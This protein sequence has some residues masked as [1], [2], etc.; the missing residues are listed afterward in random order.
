[1]GRRNPTPAGVLARI[2]LNLRR[3]VPAEARFIAAYE[4]H[5]RPQEWLRQVALVGMSALERGHLDPSVCRPSPPLAPPV[6]HPAAA[7]R[8]ALEFAVGQPD[9][10]SRG[11]DGTGSDLADELLSLGGDE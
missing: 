7:P 5:P 4:A 9:Q 1:M 6:E 10:A 11:R 3:D 2:T 8:P